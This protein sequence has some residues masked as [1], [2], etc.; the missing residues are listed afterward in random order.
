[1]LIVTDVNGTKLEIKED[2]TIIAASDLP[3]NP[4]F[5]FRKV[6]TENE[7]FKKGDVITA[8]FS[9]NDVKGEGILCAVLIKESAKHYPETVSG[10]DFTKAIVLGRFTN[11]TEPGWGMFTTLTVGTSEDLNPPAGS[12]ITGQKSWESGKYNFVMFYENKGNSI[13]IYKSIPIVI[14]Y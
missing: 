7:V 4:S 6:P 11:D 9:V 10:I 8:R 1:L 2:F 3:F 5:T 13:S 12:A 14:E